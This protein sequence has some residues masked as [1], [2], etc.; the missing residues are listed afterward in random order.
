MGVRSAKGAAKDPTQPS[1]TG[2]TGS[3]GAGSTPG[4]PSKNARSSSKRTKSTTNSII[5]LVAII[6]I[7]VLLAV[8]IQA[9]IIKPYRIPSG[10][11]EPTLIKGQRVLV[12]R[13]GMDFG[14]PHVGE[15]AVF[16][17]PEGAENEQCGSVPRTTITFGG[18]PC[19]QT[20]PQEAS[21]N[22][23]KRIVA[24]PGDSLYVKEGHVYRKAAGTTRFVR[25]GD[26]YIKPCGGVQECN[27]TTPITIPAGHWFM[28]GDNR[29][30]SDDSRFWGPVPTSWII[31]DA[32]A[33]YWPPDRIGTL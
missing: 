11:M 32:F 23:I 14:K 8:G 5:E 3:A 27:F 4:S 16:H 33:T 1:G 17:P 13:I 7:A 6:A 31:G 24:A 10:S 9:F 25:E 26:S 30:E 22:F 15:I 29:G 19:D 20:N 2:P 28:M 12:D 21:V 18:A